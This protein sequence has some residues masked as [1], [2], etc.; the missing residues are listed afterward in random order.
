MGCV[1]LGGGV[2]GFQAAFACKTYWPE[3]N[4]T[5]V[6]AEPEIGYYRTLFSISYNTRQ[7]TGN[8]HRFIRVLIFIGT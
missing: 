2:A 8:H 5:L 3:K 1:I 4:I 7:G 6:D